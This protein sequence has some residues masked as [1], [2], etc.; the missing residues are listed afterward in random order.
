LERTTATDGDRLD[1]IC[2]K[3][4]GSLDGRVVEL[5]LDANPGMAMSCELKA[6]QE[7]RLPAVEPRPK[8]QSLW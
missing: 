5:V 6:G 7:V 8:E 2:W 3:H 4:Y 1:L